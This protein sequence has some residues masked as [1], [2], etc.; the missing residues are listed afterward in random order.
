M[1]NKSTIL[2]HNIYYMLSYA[3]QELRKNNYEHI[4]GEDFE[5][6]MNLYAEILYCG[7]SEQLKK[8]LYKEYV[9]KCET[10]S[11]FRGRLDINGTIRNLVQHR[12][13]IDCEFDEFSVNN[14]YNRILKSVILLLIRKSDV[15]RKRKSQLHSI[16][17][18]FI[19]IE[20]CDLYRV[21]WDA[22]NFQR[23]NRSYRLL[24]NI[25]YMIVDGL[26]LTT[27]KGDL[28]MPTFSEHHMNRLFERF[29][30][31]YY[32]HHYP[33][34]KPN[35]DTIKWNVSNE[36]CFIGLDLLPTMHSDIT[37]RGE[38]HTLIIDTKYYGKMLQV[39]Y[40]KRTIHSSNLYQIFSYVKNLDREHRGG[41]SGMLLYAQTDEGYIPQMDGVIDGNKIMVRSLN[42]NNKFDEIKKE[43][44]QI[45]SD[46]FC[47]SP[48]LFIP[49]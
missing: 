20:E 43:L 19:D 25:C 47:Q 36:D 33:H 9:D 15:D 2:I 49:L 46:I 31:N 26:L 17:P 35:A 8:G 24:M 6:I 3:F 18:F 21:R 22:M 13:K 38:D 41:V 39:Q 16:L 23:A 28:Y 10:L 32:K 42:L 1:A 5:H 37:L 7:V 11:S 14:Q 34:L 45:V 40:G 44:N 30:L 12:H 27:D 4:D 48:P 29:V